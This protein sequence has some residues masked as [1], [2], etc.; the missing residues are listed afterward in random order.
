M[1]SKLFLKVIHHLGGVVFGG[2]S[3]LPGGGGGELAK[4]SPLCIKILDVIQTH[5]FKG[6]HGPILL[7]KRS[8]VYF[9]GGIVMPQ[10]RNKGF[11]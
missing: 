2:C 6:Q 1:T 4:I 11:H 7:C 3:G 8:N 5:I 10:H 9:K